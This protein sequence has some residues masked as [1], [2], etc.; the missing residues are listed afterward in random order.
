MKYRICLPLELGFCDL[1]V[2]VR[3]LAS[4]CLY[5]S[6]TC[7]Y[8]RVLLARA[9]KKAMSLLLTVVVLL[10]S[11]SVQRTPGKREVSSGFAEKNN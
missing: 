10:C 11:S 9:L 6:S 5:A 2:L 7:G 3:K 4:P 1:R 8:L